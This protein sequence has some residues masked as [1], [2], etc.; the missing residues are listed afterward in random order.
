MKKLTLTVALVALTLGINAQTLNVQSAIQDL[1]KGYLNKAKEEIDKACEHESTKNDAKTWCYAAMIYGQIGGESTKA[2]SK[3]KNL[4]ANWLEKAYNAALRCKELDT[5]NEY[6]DKNNSVFR[7]VGNEYYTRAVTSFNDEK[8]YKKALEDADKAIKIFNNSGDKKF[9]DDAYYLAGLCGKAM[10]DNET[11]MSY[12]K[13]LVRRKTDKTEVYNTLFNI[14]KAQSDTVEAMKLA[15]HYLKNCPNDYNAS[16]TMAQANLLRGDIDRGLEMLN[17]AVDQ[18]K[19]DPNKYT[20]MLGAAASILE[21]YGRYEEAEQKFHESL[22]LDPDQ[23]AANFGLGHMIYNRGVD[24]LS[25]ANEVP[26]DDET[27]L[28]EKLTAESNDF[29]RQSIQYF[30]AAI[31]HIDNITD[32][33]QKRMQRKNLF[34]CLNALQVVYSR[35]EMYE[36]LKPIKARIAEIQ[37]QQ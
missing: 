34:D 9:A 24:K 8:D 25:A 30:N 20:Q 19:T 12:F 26:L 3:Y 15:N 23:F 27:G 10:K 32:P 2:K 5:D 31:R 14:Y 33:E 1:K 7:Y 29:F 13:P 35:L 36:E 6:A 4:D 21:N 16:L 18:S 28:N 17:Q 11:V 37:S 22:K